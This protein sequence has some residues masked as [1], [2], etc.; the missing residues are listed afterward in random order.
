MA[1]LGQDFD[2][3][4]AVTPV[5]L[6]AGASTGARLHLRNYDGAAIVFYKAVGGAA[7]APTITVQEHN[8]ATE[9]SRLC[10]NQSGRSGR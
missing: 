10:C 2:V 5:N 9:R 6:A 1:K 3:V 7:E 8:A 4:P